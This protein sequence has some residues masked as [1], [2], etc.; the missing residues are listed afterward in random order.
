MPQD[1]EG[2]DIDFEGQLRNI[3]SWF[4]KWPIVL[5]IIVL[6]VFLMMIPSIV[7]Q[8]DRD[9]Q[10]VILRFGKFNRQVAP[11]LH[12]KLPY[13]LEDLFI[14]NTQKIFSESFGYRSK[15]AGRKISNL[16]SESLILTADLGVA[17][18]EWDV[19]FRHTNPRKFI[20]NIRNE[21]KIIRDAS[22]A[23]MRRIIG[24]Y[25]ATKVITV[26]RKKIAYEAKKELQR[27][28]DNYNSGITITDVKIQ[29]SEPPTPVAP[30]FKAVN[31]ARQIREQMRH[32]ANRQKEKVINEAEGR[33][34]QR[35]SE[36]RG[37][38]AAII[39]RA[40][41]DA[42][43]FKKVLAQYQKAPRVTEQRM[44]LETME[45]VLER[46]DRVYVLDEKIK[47]LLPLLDLKK[48]QK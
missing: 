2:P 31:S 15:P 28:M 3:G 23:A 30:A 44:F 48:G 22:L 24:D 34:Q 40:K 25:N 37:D 18:V 12:W 38:S 45:K 47:S 19:L 8:I 27:L 16:K 5:G 17:R 43:K 32:E 20:F 39:N 29:Q 9:E 1:F 42:R 6:L 41:G 13:P 4:R 35:I 36:A 33:V 26:K 11:G 10:G 46:S 21:K 14:V 7:Y